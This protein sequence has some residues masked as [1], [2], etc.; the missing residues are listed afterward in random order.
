MLDH[1]ALASHQA[2]DN[3]IRYCY[4]LG[5]RWTGGASEDEM[6]AFYFAQVEFAGGTKL[7]FLQPNPDP[8][9]DF[10]RRFLHRNGPG[11]HHFTFKVP[12]VLLPL[13]ISSPVF[14]HHILTSKIF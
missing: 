7:E 11:P 8:G 13:P 4:H 2:W 10:I 9:S 12:I 5:A 1:L 3:L 6:T 14:F